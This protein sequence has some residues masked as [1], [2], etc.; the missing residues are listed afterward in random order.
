MLIGFFKH[1]NQYTMTALL[2]PFESKVPKIYQIGFKY[3][4]QLILLV[5]VV[6]CP[7]D[8]AINGAVDFRALLVSGPGQCGLDS[9][10]AVNG[11]PWDS[12][13]IQ[14]LESEKQVLDKSLGFFWRWFR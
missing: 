1:P 14:K 7:A 9:D 5:V 13:L 12:K 10:V 4:L 11:R 3:Q 6:V 2:H 8:G